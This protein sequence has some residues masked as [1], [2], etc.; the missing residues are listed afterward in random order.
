MVGRVQMK[1]SIRTPQLSP[2]Q[3]S[4]EVMKDGLQTEQSQ[5]GHKTF[6]RQ[7]ATPADPFKRPLS[8]TEKPENLHF[9]KNIFPPSP[10][11]MERPKPASAA[12]ACEL[13]KQ[14][15]PCVKTCNYLR[16]YSSLCG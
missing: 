7:N 11:E 13:T 16:R 8:L 15:K 5:S 1:D 10:T 3:A 12:E 4:S 9:V 6:R 2:Q 14:Q